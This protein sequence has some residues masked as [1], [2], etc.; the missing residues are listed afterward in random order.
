MRKLMNSLHLLLD[1]S[2]QFRKLNEEEETKRKPFWYIIWNEIFPKSYENLDI[3][4][5]QKSVFHTVSESLGA[6]LRRQKTYKENIPLQI[7]IP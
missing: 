7:C 1:W 6:G 3:F 2:L 5:D 4:L